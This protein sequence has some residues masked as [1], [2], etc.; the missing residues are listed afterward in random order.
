MKFG[1]LALSL[2][3]V[4]T[5]QAPQ[6]DVKKE[7]DKLQGNWAVT[8]MNGQDLPA[9]AEVY[10]TFKDD[11]YEQWVSGSVQERGSIK[12][13]NKTKPISIDLVITEGN[14]A[15]KTQ[16]GVYELNGD[17]LSIGLAIAGN[18]ARPSTVA[19]G[20]LQAVLKKVK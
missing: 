5:G 4:P 11:K 7:F 20:E 17:T 13:D 12:I 15:G 18:T 2:L 19:Q 6:D 3:F 14:D 9:E 16:P 8:S 1:I 10:L